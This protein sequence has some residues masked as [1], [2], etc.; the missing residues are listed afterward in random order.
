MTSTIE[1]PGLVIRTPRG[2]LSVRLRP[3][4]VLV[5]AVLLLAIL[6]VGVAALTIG[7]FPMPAADVFRTLFGEGRPGDDFIVNELRLPRL[8][9][10][11]LVGAALGISGSLFQSLTRNP[12]GSPD[13][14]GL[15]VGAASGALIM[16]LV[17]DGDAYQ[18]AAGAI[19]GCLITSVVI[20]LLAYR[21]GVQGFRLILIG[22]GIS[23]MLEAVNSYLIIHSTLQQARTAQVWLIGSLNARGWDAVAP[24]AVALAVLVPLVLRYARRLPMMELGDDAATAVGVPVERTRLVLI[25][26]SVALCA[27]ATAAAGPV[28]FVALAA[29]QLAARL[30]GGGRPS[31]IV[32][33]LMGALLL[34]VSDLAAQR[35]FA[36]V[37]LPVGVA[38]SAIG[39]VYL[40]WLIG[41]EWRRG[42]G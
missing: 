28:V 36:P 16:I 34:A 19:I 37:Q 42:R 17:F 39:G 31:P 6:A 15:T 20:Y 22:I 10:G 9:T 40:A 30:V 27:V 14:V 18:V 29:P 32:A 2:G 3:R 38:T 35:V 23:A 26:I 41:R 24:V 33:G 11:L 5:A 25:L 21:N 4:S 1:R 13:L 8:L 7:D 12:L